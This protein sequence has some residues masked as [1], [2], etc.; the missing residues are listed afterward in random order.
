MQTFKTFT[1]GKEG[2]GVKTL[3]FLGGWPDDHSLWDGQI[4][5]L[6]S[7]YRCVTIEVPLPTAREWGLSFE[8]LR[9]EL[10]RTVNE[11]ASGGP[12]T[13]IAH[14]WGC[15]IAYQM[16]RESS[17]LVEKFISLDI[18]PFPEIRFSSLLIVCYQ[19]ML[20]VSC[21]IGGRIG[22]AL[23][24]FVAKVL[25]WPLYAQR[26]ASLTSRNSFYYPRYAWSLIT[27]SVKGRGYTPSMPTL[28][29]HAD[30]GLANKVKFYRSSWVEALQ[31]REDSEV[32]R[33]ATGAHWFLLTHPELTNDMIT[34]FVEGDK[35]G[36]A[37]S[38]SPPEKEMTDVRPQQLDCTAHAV[39]TCSRP[40][41]TLTRQ[42]AILVLPVG[43]KL[44]YQADDGVLGIEPKVHEV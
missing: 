18:G 30:A 20:I 24:R 15:I 10:R 4:A 2:P 35:V 40:F 19:L 17:D 29:A 32:I 38:R 42:I 39:P 5:A 27:G 33:F 14:D 43:C 3:V 28:F 1:S 9:S 23:T 26:G 16:L 22:A 41:A 8:L 31:A 11:A 34:A 12:V 36:G 7:K 6:Q 21:L 44:N 13:L 37:P 25:G